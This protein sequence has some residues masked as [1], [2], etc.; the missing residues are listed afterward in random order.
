MQEHQNHNP[1]IGEAPSTISIVASP[2]PKCVDISFPH[3]Q[4]L[5][6]HSLPSLENQDPSL[7][8]MFKKMWP[9]RTP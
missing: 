6:I 1:L 4:V 7:T 9:P 8:E 3:D 2:Y 5:M